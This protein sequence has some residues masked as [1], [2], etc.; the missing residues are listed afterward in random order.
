M[1]YSLIILLQSYLEYLRPQAYSNVIGYIEK[2]DP[3]IEEYSYH[4]ITATGI[5]MTST[6]VF[7]AIG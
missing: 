5:K 1:M 7:V 6:V 4:G 2:Y 3:T